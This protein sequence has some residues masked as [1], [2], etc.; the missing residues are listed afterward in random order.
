MSLCRVSVLCGGTAILSDVSFDIPRGQSCAVIGPNGA[1]KST[2][3]AVMSGY[4]WP[5]RGRVCV[6]DGEF[7][8]VSLS[9]VRK[10]VAVIEQSRMP[11]FGFN[12]TGREVVATGLF[13][14][15]QL[16]IYRDL[17]EDEWAKVDQSL[18][19]IGVGQIADRRY[20]QLSSGEQMKILLARVMVA[21]AE[22]VILDEPTAGL[23]I[24]SRAEVVSAIEKLRANDNRKTVIVVG[25]HINELGGDV[26]RVIMLREG[27][28]FRD[29]AIDK[30]LTSE[31]MSEL[32][33]CQIRVLRSDGRYAA[34]AH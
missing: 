20:W 27:Q 23:D 10:R 8:K 24:R 4:I 29:G 31:N 28:K 26:E 13:G 17:T 9:D 19:D 30:V 3:I 14:S 2:L 5:S 34:I 11:A 16:P 21:H 22:V 15:L 6:L 25:H 18:E 33:G 12:M 7:G 1:G 32:Y